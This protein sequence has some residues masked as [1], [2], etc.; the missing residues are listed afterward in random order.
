MEIK[1]LYDKLASIYSMLNELNVQGTKNCSIVGVI[2]SNL[3]QIA[4]ELNE[5]IEKKDKE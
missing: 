4:K 2:A 3:E 1:P 5:E